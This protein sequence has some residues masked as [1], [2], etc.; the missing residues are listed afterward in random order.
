MYDKKYPITYTN[1]TFYQVNLILHKYNILVGYKWVQTS[2]ISELGTI[3]PKLNNT[4]WMCFKEI[5]YVF[6]NIIFSI[7][8]QIKIEMFPLP[9]N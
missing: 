4:I 5:N 8:I 9:V 6:S 7:L 3:L 2:Q 1:M